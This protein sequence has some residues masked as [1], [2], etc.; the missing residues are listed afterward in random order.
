MVDVSTAEDA[1]VAAELAS[2]GQ[3]DDEEAAVTFHSAFFAKLQAPYF[4]YA[5]NSEE[6][7]LMVEYGDQ[8][9]A[10]TFPASAAN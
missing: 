6:P 5:E 10:L 8:E 9:V 7:V 4:R 1:A 3:V 2:D